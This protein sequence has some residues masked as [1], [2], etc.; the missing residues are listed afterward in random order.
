MYILQFD[1]M[2]Q[3]SVP[4]IQYWEGILGYGWLIRK[5]GVEIAHGFGLFAHC[6]TASSSMAE[7][8]ALIEGLDAPVDLRVENE[9]I[10]IHGDAKCVI[11]QMLGSSSVSSLSLRKLHRR[12]CK[13]AHNFHSLSWCWVPRQK[14]GQAD[15]LSRR[16]LR[17]LGSATLPLHRMG[18]TQSAM[19]P[20]VNLRV[21]SPASLAIQHTFIPSRN[22]FT[23]R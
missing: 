17:Y 21:H 2:Y 23:N 7:Y 8:L 5:N 4:E 22:P 16:G 1:G 9:A 3:R 6:R 13:L 20:I 18:R 11:D 19:Y 14:N 12:A 15:Q 10:E